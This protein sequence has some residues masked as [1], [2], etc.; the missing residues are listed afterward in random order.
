VARQAVEVRREEILRAAVE[1]IAARGFANTRVADVAAAMGVSTALLFYHFESK[2]RLLS[3]A[4]E[5]AA[6]RDLARLGRLAS[7]TTPA[8]QRLS[9]ILSLYGPGTTADQGW[10]LWIEAWAAALRVPELQATSRR[11]DV[12]WKDTVAAV[13][14]DGV[15]AGEFRC[16]DPA[17]AAWRVTAL[18][19][20][21][22]IQTTVHRG[23]L[24]RRTVTRWARA[25]AAAE[26]GIPV[27]ALG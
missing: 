12:R 15:E 24:S 25:A 26:L 6:E 11:L 18:L 17:A 5:Y 2:D 19:D 9:R 3:E 27:D 20:G 22:A 10:P 16:D 8:V 7:A 13:I 21:L 4:F 23:L 14:R 1:Q